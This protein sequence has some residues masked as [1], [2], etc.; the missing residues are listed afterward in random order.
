[1]LDYRLL[2][3]LAAVVEQ[4]GFE[5]AARRLALSQSAVSQRIKLLEARLGQPVVVRGTPVTAT[6]LGRRLLHHAQ[7]VRLLESD[8]LAAVPALADSEQHRLRVALNADSLATWWSEAA[9]PFCIEREVLLELVIEDQD[10]GLK[11]MRAGDVAACLCAAERPVPGARSVPLGRMR[12]RAL[13]TPAYLER[14]F[15]AGVDEAALARAPAV[16]FGPDDRL[17][18]RFLEQLGLRAEFPSHLCPS[19]EGYLR[20]VAAGLGYGLVPQIQAQALIERG[21]LRDLLPG[22]S[23]EVALYWHHWRHGGE[24]LD[25]LTAHLREASRRWL[26]A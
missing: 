3:A 17:Q 25:A 20:A 11:R 5:R 18:H 16:L 10:V 6:E 26:E 21:A 19:S 4:G 8:L 24:L 15:P 22:E 12:Y 2:A 7:Q 23:L 14:W 13:A 1:M 9:G